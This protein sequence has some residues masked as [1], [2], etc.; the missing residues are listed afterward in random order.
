MKNVMGIIFMIFVITH[1]GTA[2]D[3]R[4]IVNVLKGI[5]FAYL[6]GYREEFVNDNCP[7]VCLPEPISYICQIIYTN[8]G[9]PSSRHCC[10]Y[11]MRIN[12]NSPNR[13][14]AFPLTDSQLTVNFPED[15]TTT[16]KDK[17]TSNYD[18]ITTT[19]NLPSTTYETIGLLGLEEDNKVEEKNDVQDKDN[20]SCSGVCVEQ[21]LTNNCEAY[22]NSTDL[23]RSGKRCCVNITS[24]GDSLPSDLI[25]TSETVRPTE[26]SPTTTT[27]TGV[28]TS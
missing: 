6:A 15:S 26:E 11:N 8:A 20:I 3:F 25:V 22:F 14:V 23:C 19:T 28:T 21:H 16:V 9:C 1:L 18:D 13:T 4:P 17:E 2:Q 24:F 7:G 12:I 5:F 27:D 10:V